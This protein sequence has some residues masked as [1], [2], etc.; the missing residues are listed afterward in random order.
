MSTLSLI[1]IGIALAA[2]AGLCFGL[3]DHWFCTLLALACLLGGLDAAYRDLRLWALS[4]LVSG[5][6]CAGGATYSI[7]A[8]TRQR[9]Q[10]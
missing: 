7:Y 3:A 10:R 6:M 1:A 8:A 9:R 2:V 5:A 4:F